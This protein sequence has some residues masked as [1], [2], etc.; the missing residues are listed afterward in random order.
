MASFFGGQQGYL[1]N[2][3]EMIS[4][5]WDNKNKKTEVAGM[6]GSDVLAKG[7]GDLAKT[8]EYIQN[9]IP[10]PAIGEFT[11]PTFDKS[12]IRKAAAK[13]AA[14]YMAEQREMLGDVMQESRGIDNPDARASFVN[15]ATKGFGTGVA[16]IAG[17][18]EDAA[19]DENWQ[20]YMGTKLQPAL[21]SYE[22]KTR[23]SLSAYNTA[24]TALANYL[25][26]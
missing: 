11:A 4:N 19:T 21:T 17:A 12:G 18:A 26:G 3:G 6:L 20:E 15:R 1:Q 2:I 14:P 9:A 7:S 22:A 10:Q 8:A 13:K 5:W 24:M 23:G 25:R 16:K